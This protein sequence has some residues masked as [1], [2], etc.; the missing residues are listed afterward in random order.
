MRSAVRGALAILD[1]LNA[2]V[3]F[4]IGGLLAVISAVVLLQVIVRFVLTS[5]GI[6]IAAPW[7]EELARYLLVWMIFLGAALGCRKMQ[8]ISL[9]FVVTGVP[10]IA[11]IAMRVIA[12][13]LCLLLFA[14][15]LRYGTDFVTVIGRTELSP[16]MQVPKTWVYWAMPAGAALMIANTLAFIAESWLEGRDIRQSGGLADEA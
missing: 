3:Y 16:V 11:G 5:V 10:R 8:L 9:G 1:R 2:G 13:A 4:A 6:N 14:L 12:L 7:T 15:L